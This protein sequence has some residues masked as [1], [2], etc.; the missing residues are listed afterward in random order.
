MVEEG[1]AMKRSWKGLR[2]VISGFSQ[3]SGGRPLKPGETIE[4]FEDF[5]PYN[6][7]VA[8]RTWEQLP[9]ETKQTLRELDSERYG[10]RE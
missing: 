10:G 2:R 6:L 9:E 5:W 7:I 3:G 1:E 4:I 8:G